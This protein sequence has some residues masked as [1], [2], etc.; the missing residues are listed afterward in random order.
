MLIPLDGT[1]GDKI[2]WKYLW[3]FNI[4]SKSEDDFHFITEID[5]CDLVLQPD[6]IIFHQN[7]FLNTLSCSSGF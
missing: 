2:A 7:Q 3:K 6:V 4:A 1:E 5:K